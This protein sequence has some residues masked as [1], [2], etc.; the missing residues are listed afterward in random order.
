MQI[1]TTVSYH[2]T[3][4]GMAIVRNSIQNSGE[5]MEK[6][7]CKSVQSP[8]KTGW[9][10]LKKLKIDLSYDPEIPLLSVLSEENKNTN[11]KR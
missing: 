11:S 4:I 9:N 5:G 10:F 8:W 3:P 7:E 2:F 6:R 1:K